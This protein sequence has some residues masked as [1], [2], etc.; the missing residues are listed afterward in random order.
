VQ[1]GRQQQEPAEAIWAFTPERSRNPRPSGRGGCQSVSS[2][3]KMGLVL[4]NKTTT[5][6]VHQLVDEYLSVYPDQII[7]RYLDFS[8]KN[9][10]QII[11]GSLDA[12]E[13][14]GRHKKVSAEIL[15]KRKKK[16]AAKSKAKNRNKK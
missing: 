4:C 8:K 6:V 16:M 7:S 2:H 12:S 10:P 13:M 14:P 11:G 1:Q 9:P 15:V 3:L 5:N